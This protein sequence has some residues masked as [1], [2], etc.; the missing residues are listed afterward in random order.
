MVSYCVTVPKRLFLIIY[1]V[2][3]WLFS[4]L[5]IAQM[6]ALSYSTHLDFLKALCNPT[7]YIVIATVMTMAHFVQRGAHDSSQMAEL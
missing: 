2:R 5:D 4:H 7:R 3:S 1:T 6:R